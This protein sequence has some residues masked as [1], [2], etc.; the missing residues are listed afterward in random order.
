MTETL[1][2]ED[3]VSWRRKVQDAT[4]MEELTRLGIEMAYELDL[5]KQAMEVADQE[6]GYPERKASSEVQTC[7]CNFCRYARV[8]MK[9]DEAASEVV[10]DEPEFVPGNDLDE[11]D[12][13]G[14]RW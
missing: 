10:E 2:T 4:S 14:T 9:I 7:P 1:T 8:H 3:V 13:F 5:R 6:F 11:S 12:P